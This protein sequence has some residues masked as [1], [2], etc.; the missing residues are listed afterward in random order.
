MSYDATTELITMQANVIAGS[1]AA[2]GWGAS[3]TNTEIVHFRADSASSA[4]TNW[5]ATGTHMPSANSAVDACYTSSFTD[6]GSSVD[7]TVT[8]PLDCGIDTSYV[9]QV[10]AELDLIAA[11]NPK[12]P[13]MSFHGANHL[14]FKQTLGSDGTCG[15]STF[16][17]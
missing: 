2:W 11:W 4:V 13:E 15:A 12:S 5:F 8:R 10:D 9:V 14:E 7:F 3:M 17:Q 1:Y 16:L 6:G